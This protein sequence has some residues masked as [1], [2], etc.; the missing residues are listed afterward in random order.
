MSEL[1]AAT[2]KKLKVGEIKAELS[3]RNLSIL[4]KKDELASRLLKVIDHGLLKPKSAED[5]YAAMSVMS[6]SRDT[7][8][9][10]EGEPID[11]IYEEEN[12]KEVCFDDS[13]MK[14]L[15]RVSTP[16]QR[17]LFS[18][19]ANTL[20]KTPPPERSVPP[21][22]ADIYISFER[23]AKS[24][25]ELQSL[26]QTERDRNLTLLE[27]NFSLKLK[28]GQKVATTDCKVNNPEKTKELTSIIKKQNTPLKSPI[29]YESI[30][31][32]DDDNRATKKTEGKRKK[33][34]RSKEISNNKV[35]GKSD[36]K[37][38]HTD[39]STRH[40]STE[41]ITANCEATGEHQMKRTARNH[42]AHQTSRQAAAQKVQASRQ[43]STQQPF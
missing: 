8:E 28:L 2:I 1:N 5:R 18:A 16:P 33:K 29:V 20:N 9:D 4:G 22:P 19:A 41:S 42:I 11:A 12:V 36:T 39:T 25:V 13:F 14:F 24:V 43:K 23:L 17:P 31:I 34:K 38:V 7:Q 35:D 15:D 26:L 27:E 21:P 30:E 10:A 3:K 37:A 6:D 32:V 40:A